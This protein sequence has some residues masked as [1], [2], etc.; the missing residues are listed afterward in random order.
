MAISKASHNT[1]N[2][3][4]EGKPAEQYLSRGDF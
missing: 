1:V 3:D 4:V 2:L